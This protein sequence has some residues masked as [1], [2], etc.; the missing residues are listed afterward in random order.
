MKNL[1]KYGSQP[2]DVAVVHGGPG[3]P[4]EMAPVARE[5]ASVRG[6]LEPLQ[7]ATTLEGQVE[8]LKVVLE[9]NAALP[10]TLIGF[11]WGAM[12]GFI[13]CARYPLLVKK[14]VLVGSGV[15]DER[16]AADVTVTR[17]SRLG[18]EERVAVLSLAEAMNGPATGDKNTAM[19]RMGELM[20]RVDLYDPLPYDSEILEYRYDIYRVVWRQAAELR[21]QGEFLALGK[22]IHCPVVAIHGDY[23]PHPAAGVKDSLS[24]VIKDFRFILLAKC[25]HYPWR[26]RSARDS[27]YRILKN[28]V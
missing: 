2:F 26:E 13:L 15:Y 9:E 21:K 11:S 28:E 14:L 1:R 18:E 3:A 16:Y 7:T 20:A 22:R 25:G 17:L 8:E 10:V 27:F 5:L 23:D 24:P 4:G 12:L 19:A 6:I